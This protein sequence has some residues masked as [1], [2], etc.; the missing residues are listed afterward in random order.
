MAGERELQQ[1][2]SKLRLFLNRVTSLTVVVVAIVAIVYLT[3]DSL[4]DRW[5]LMAAIAG[6]V[7]LGISFPIVSQV[8]SG[9]RFWR[10]MN[11]RLKPQ[12]FVA[13]T[14]L[15]GL[16][17]IVLFIPSAPNEIA[18]AAVGG[19]VA[20]AKDIITAPDEPSEGPGDRAGSPE[21]GE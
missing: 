9:A 2:E 17:G 18:A 13:V 20:L 12:I 6:A 11:L 10:W 1:G 8:G 15:G 19:I 7:I 16:G 21:T 14:L 4:S 5:I 3:R